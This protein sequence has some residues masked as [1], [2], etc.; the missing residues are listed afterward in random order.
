MSYNCICG[1]FEC[2]NCSSWNVLIVAIGTV[3]YETRFGGMS[4]NRLPETTLFVKA[5]QDLF[6]ATPIVNYFPMK[7][8]QIFLRKWQKLHDDSWEILFRTSKKC[9]S[10]YN[11]VF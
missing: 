8:N 5:V 7:V 6:L 1:T 3:L 11:L 4:E 9:S 2:S 10:V